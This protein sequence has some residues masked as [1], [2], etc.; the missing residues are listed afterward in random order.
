M[1]VRRLVS[2]LTASAILAAGLGVVIAAP[3]QATQ[4]K[5]RTSASLYFSSISNSTATTDGCN[6]G[7]AAATSPIQN[8]EVALDWGA[9]IS[10]TSTVT[11]FNGSASPNATLAQIVSMA[12]AY[13]DA[14]FSCTAGDTTSQLHLL[15]VAPN[16]GGPNSTEGAQWANS[17]VDPV[18]AHVIA[19][20]ENS[21]VSA[22][23]G[24]D[25]EPAW[26]AWAGT[27]AWADYYDANV[28]HG[29]LVDIGS[30][31][32]CSTSTYSNSGCS[33][34]W[35]Q[36]DEY[37]LAWHG[38]SRNF[39]LPEIY[40][41]SLALQWTMISKYGGVSGGGGYVA[42]DGPLSTTKTGYLSPTSAWDDFWNDLNNN[43]APSSP[44]FYYSTNI[45]F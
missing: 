9:Q 21:Q 32:G 38:N 40:T 12:E 1:S 8:N 26:G 45:T 29:R 5:P 3:S 13:L 42:Y 4:A 28:A 22:E 19:N 43:G 7:K 24:F 11:L 31:D 20:Y 30:A 44:T 17:V 33:N 25:A 41:S 10:G 36:A 2:L 37:Y 23:G 35:N 14:W 34:G 15:L 6:Q 18:E 39:A 27:K 16:D